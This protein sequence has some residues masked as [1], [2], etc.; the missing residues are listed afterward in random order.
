MEEERWGKELYV[1]SSEV[2]FGLSSIHLEEWTCGS[3]RVK[4][5]PGRR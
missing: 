4:P 5:C 3:H 2:N 1:C